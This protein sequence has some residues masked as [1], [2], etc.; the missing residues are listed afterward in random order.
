M[1]LMREALT[2]EPDTLMVVSCYHIGK[3][4]A[5]LGAAAAL[6]LKVCVCVCL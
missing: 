3:E 2:E 1:Q 4:R 5:F 6:G